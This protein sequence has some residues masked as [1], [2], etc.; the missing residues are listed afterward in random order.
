MANWPRGKRQFGPRL[1]R[2]DTSE[3][4]AGRCSAHQQ[5]REWG[6]EF[7]D[8]VELTVIIMPVLFVRWWW[9]Q[10]D[11]CVGHALLVSS[12]ATL[13]KE[14][15]GPDWHGRS[16]GW[17]GKDRWPLHDD[18]LSRARQALTTLSTRWVRL[19]D[20]PW[21]VIF[22]LWM[23]CFSFR[24]SEGGTGALISLPWEITAQRR[25]RNPWW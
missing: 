11:S 6:L 15:A 12:T 19:A 3:A 20:D 14:Y 18:A 13:L 4:N 2:L 22:F 23:A 9:R 25:K 7:E 8:S 10:G 16:R 5:Q 1:L 21:M 24:G 17:K